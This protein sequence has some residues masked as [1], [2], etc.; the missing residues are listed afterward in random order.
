MRREYS[1]TYEFQE[2]FNLREL[3]GIYLSRWKW[4]LAAIIVFL[5]MAYLMLRYSNPVFESK[6]RVLIKIEKAGAYSELSAFQDLGLFEGLSGY[7][8]MYNE[9]EILHSRPLIE[10]VVRKLGLNVEYYL[11]GS[12]TG[13]ERKEFY[14]RAPIQFFFVDGQDIKKGFSHVIEI[15]DCNTFKFVDDIDFGNKKFLFGDTLDNGSSKFT[16]ECTKYYNE[17][18][19]NIQISI[20]ASS[21]ES[22]VSK[23]QSLLF[24]EPIDEQIDILELSIRGSLIDRN[25]DFLDSLIAE[26]TR[27]TITDQLT[28]YHNT[29]DF[30]NDRIESI[31]EELSEVEKD[32]ESYKT[33]NELS[34]VFLNEKSLYDRTLFNERNLVE[35]EI[36][37]ELSK[38]LYD[39]LTDIEDYETLIPANL[40]LEEESINKSVA[41]YNKIALE[42]LKLT[43]LSSNKNPAV[44]KLENEL[45]SI[46]TSLKAGLRNSRSSIELEVKKLRAEQGALNSDI[47]DLPKHNRILRSIDR[48]Q[49]VKE[50]LYL[51]L[52]QKREENEIASAVTEGN[53]K[54]V[55]SAYCNGVIV[56]PN[57]KMY[58]AAA[59][60]LG[61]L[62][63]FSIIYLISLFDNKVRTKEDLDKF[64]LP[65]LGNVPH[66]N[67][68]EKIVIREGDTSPGAEAFRILRTNTNFV[69]KIKQ[70]EGQIIMVTST[71][72]K[73][74]KSFIAL[75]LA[76]SF[77]LTGKKTVVV[78]LDLRA[79][80]LFKYANLGKSKG[81]T[82][83]ILDNSIDVDSLI[84]SSKET[85]NL[86]FLPAGVRPPNPSELL[87]REELAELF[88]LL[89]KKY[90]IVIVDTAPMGL[91]TDTLLVANQSD[92]LLY[93]VRANYLEKK[94]LTIPQ[95][96]LE[97]KSIRNVGVVLNAI[98]KS[99][100]GSYGY[101]YGY[102]QPT[103]ND[104]NK[105]WIKR[106]FGRS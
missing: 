15:I 18:N 4:F 80:R 75:N 84:I 21:I 85:E 41:E 19:S 102:G 103:N 38:Y 53:S 34:D 61:L 100:R 29:T 92:A 42:R 106:L 55:E 43:Q 39:F 14:K 89:K 27:M 33:E 16:L 96:L 78:G 68:K 86:S 24:V 22:T 88:S 83:L 59:L 7:N 97:K 12:K 50:S 104:D 17:E 99:G 87:L 23:Y 11:L 52:L 77:A 64:R 69:L 6:A 49:Q 95:E 54:I 73:E 58:Y 20:R 45:N 51:Y 3:L 79:P 70:D 81:V 48:Q 62:I 67:S 56:A 57:K 71:I 91:V 13:I 8:N 46:I 101:Q 76:T 47:S 44:L 10:K 25:N 30:I 90:D 66:I 2:E 72:A 98:T 93:V 40:G 31:A 1:S 82:E 35:A 28:I 5:G 65:H 105:N 60:F 36:Q 63:P 74:G 94:M 37:L 32:G 26:H 9:K